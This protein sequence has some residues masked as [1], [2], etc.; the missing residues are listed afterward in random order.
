M[1]KRMF[2][3]SIGVALLAAMLTAGCGGGGGGDGGGAANTG[4]PGGN[5]QGVDAF[6]AAVDA[7]IAT[8]NADD[9]EPQSTANATPT[10]DDSS[11]P[12]AVKTN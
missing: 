12:Y 11:E 4:N 8:P 9:V 7:V 5:G 3:G 10:A 2:K 1:M 6:V